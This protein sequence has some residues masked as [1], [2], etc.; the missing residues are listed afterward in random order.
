M[1]L[2]FL[3]LILSMAVLLLFSCLL[4]AVKKVSWYSKQVKTQEN[5]LQTEITNRQQFST[6]LVELKKQYD[7]NLLQDN[8]TGLSSKLV[9][10]D[11]MV[12]A[13]NQ[14][15]RYQLTLGVICLDID[16][17]NIINSALGYDVGD[18]L[19]KEIASRLQ[20]SV[21]QVDTVC[22]FSGDEFV[23]LLPQIAKAETCVYI[24]QRLLDTISQP[25]HI[26]DQDLFITASIGISVYPADGLD[27]KT[28][29]K[30]ANNALNQ[31]KTRG[32]NI[33][34][35]YRKEMH[36]LSQRELVLNAALRDG[37]IYREFTL[38]YQPLV[39][40]ST[41]EVICM[42]ALLRWEHPEFG[43]ITPH[44][45]LRLAENSGKI[46]EIGEWV[47][48]TVCQQFQAWKK[49]NFNLTKVAVNISLRQLE[50]PHFIFKLTQIL[51][52]MQISPDTLI[53]EISEGAFHKIEL[54]E[55]CL[56]LLKNIGVKIAID[57]FGTGNLSLQQ[58]KRLSID[59]LKIDRSFVQ[60]LTE[61]KESETIIKM[62]IA[63]AK[64]LGQDIIAEGVETREQKQQL[65]Q[66][67]CHVMQGHLFS[68]PRKAEEFTSSIEKSIGEA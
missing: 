62:M 44:D 3:S 27:G 68:I 16:E 12:Q 15:K 6:Q 57:D 26:Q 32:C 25:F 60:E 39:N 33:Y 30:N 48:R 52:E 10:E 11:R 38:F 24:A 29:L 18:D 63:L 59:Y 14:S 28:L 2:S 53:L 35:F 40:T 47:L 34:Q 22:R 43:L 23:L 66:W 17:F 54:L 1:S 13:V 50:N 58:L 37:S 36:E 8:L 19:L 5:Q 56:T 31:A 46:I 41:K 67:G 65:E 4:Y 21:R 42:E 49:L 64:G 45:F 9:L 51:Q 61:N 55:K 20:G 7:Q